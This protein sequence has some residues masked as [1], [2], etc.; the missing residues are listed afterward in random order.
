M[1]GR[2]IPSFRETSAKTSESYVSEPKRR[3]GL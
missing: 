2:N 3:L 1:L